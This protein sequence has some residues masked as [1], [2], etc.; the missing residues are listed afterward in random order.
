MIEVK[1]H[2]TQDYMKC[3]YCRGGSTKIYDV[4]FYQSNISNTTLCLC[5][6]C[7]LELKNKIES[8]LKIGKDEIRD[9]G[10]PMV[11]LHCDYYANN[12]DWCSYHVCGT[13]CDNTCR[14]WENTYYLKLKEE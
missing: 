13:S 2:D 4:I 11:C 3:I 10:V 1:E 6:N 7:L 5:E 14:Q 12:W 8:M 9:L